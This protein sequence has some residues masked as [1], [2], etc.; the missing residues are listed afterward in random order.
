M[1]ESVYWSQLLF[2]F[3]YA[4]SSFFHVDI[5]AKNRKVAV[6]SVRLFGFL[7]ESVWN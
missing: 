7:T 2:V 4:S 5:L 6:F 1:S 3:V